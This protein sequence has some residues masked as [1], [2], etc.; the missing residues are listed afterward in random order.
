V[1]AVAGLAGRRSIGRRGGRVVVICDEIAAAGGAVG[2]E[3]ADGEVHTGV[4]D[5]DRDVGRALLRVPGGE[6]VPVDAGDARGTDPLA[7]IP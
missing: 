3:V 6:E 4:D 2:G 7:G 5:R 1:G